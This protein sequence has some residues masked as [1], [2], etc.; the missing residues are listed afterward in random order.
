MD[1]TITLSKGRIVLRAKDDTY[2]AVRS[3]LVGHEANAQS[4]YEMQ[5]DE[6]A[7]HERKLLNSIGSALSELKSLFPNYAVN[8]TL[9][10]SMDSFDVEFEVSE[11]FD[12]DKRTD[13]ERLTEEYLYRRVVADWWQTNYPD[14]AAPYVQSY[15][16]SLEALKRCFVLK[17][18]YESIDGVK[19]K[20]L[21]RRGYRVVLLYKEEILN[22]IHS[23]MLR[24]SRMK[25]DMNLQTSEIDDETMLTRYVNRHVG[26]IS[27]RINA[28]LYELSNTVDNDR[29]D[30]T[31]VYEFKLV[32]PSGWDDRLFEQLAEEMHGYVINATLFEW[33]KTVDEKPALVYE[34]QAD[35]AWSNIKH[36]VSVRRGGVNKP[37]QPF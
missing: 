35:S 36:I 22:E 26:R 2:L 11:R 31:P 23:E 1:L 16:Q 3:Y 10:E 20:C 13:I 19:Y 8:D 27:N 37:L 25:S 4:K 34:S 30:R 33:L 24:L 12:F 29:M 15:M 7:T 28:Y 17:N 18:P 32:M 21:N 6:R 14:A 5:A 9:R